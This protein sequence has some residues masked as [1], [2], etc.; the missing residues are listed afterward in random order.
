M[1]GD[2]FGNGMLLSSRLRIVAAFDHRHVFLDPD[3]DPA[4]SWAERERLFDLPRSSWADYDAS[5]ISPGGGV[6][7]RAQKTI[8]LTDQVRRSLGIDNSI[9]RMRPDELIAAILTAPVDLLWNG[10]I[11]TYVKA[12]SES[13]EDVGDRNNDAVRVDASDLRCA[14][15]GEG[16]NLG[17]TQLAR[18]EFA[19]T[20][21]LISTDAIDNSA[22]VDCSDHEVNIKITL[23][24][25]VR[26]GDLTVKQRNELLAEMT[27]D[28]AE[29]V[30]DHNRE[31]T[32]AL[33]IARRQALPMVNVHARY[34]DALESEGLIDR[35]LEFLPSDKA[36]AERQANHQGMFTPEFAVMI[37]YTKQVD[38]QEVLGSD[39]PDDPVLDADLLAYFPTA[40]QVRYPEQIRAHRLRREIIATSLINNMVNLSGI[41]F[42]HRM[43]EGTGATVT[44]VARAFVVARTVTEF[45]RLWNEVDQ[46]VDLD[47][48]VQ[49]DVFLDVRRMAE[50]SSTWLLRNRRSPLDI[51]SGIETFR[52]GIAQLAT[53]MGDAA[54]GRVSDDIES[55]RARRLAEGVPPALAD[56]AAQWPW[57]H[58]GFDIVEI[59]RRRQADISVVART[60]WSVFDA[61]DL[62]WLWDGVGALPRSD[63]WQTQGR[64]ALRDDLL[65]V[66][67][68][69]TGHVLDSAGGDPLAWIAA[70]ERL[71][72]RAMA[73]HTEIR[74]AESFDMTTLSVG[75]RQLRNL[76]ITAVGP[77]A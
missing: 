65:A 32:L 48:D 7:A 71:A 63:R 1:S 68:A 55:L 72:T 22:G 18:V 60:Y 9:E 42:D 41:S 45:S 74:R 39:L 27:G 3:P 23:D 25:L 29:L 14:I 6:H 36:I 57:L 26:S 33:M 40:L 2:V 13:D 54:V 11:G 75:L 17:L 24:Q 12:S 8:E 67:A 47:P 49:V 31:Q 53:S 10:G 38:V 59:S 46:L 20:G 43:T 73:M 52:D 51:A 35:S 61:L 69:L 56:R 66:M 37:A 28:V 30:L 44:D 76:T 62:G 15:V 21:G 64:A 19:E 77:H 34:L 50:R 16:G 4:A 70:N 5:L 58:T